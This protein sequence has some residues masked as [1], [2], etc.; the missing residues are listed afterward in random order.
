MKRFLILVFLLVQLNAQ[1]IYA[2]FDVV[3]KK[4]A[5]LAFIASGI[6]DKVF[7]EVG[8]AVKEGEILAVLQNDDIKASLEMAK[9]TLKYA[10]KSYERQKKV[11]HLIDEAKFD[12]VAKRYEEA[13]VAYKLKT[14]LYKQTFLKAPFDGIIYAKHIEVGDAVSKMRLPTVLKIQSSSERKLLIHFDQKYIKSVH[15]GDV[16]RY[17]TDSQ[18]SY[19]NAKIAKIYPVSDTK[20]RKITA[21]VYLKNLTPGLFGDGYIIT[22]E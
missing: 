14:V 16:F 8:D 7:V 5:S 6:V 21:E 20:N 10:K 1:E 19:H 18:N 13:K 12:Q 2:T 4:D 17:K 22:K 11:R 9:I 3:A 15:I